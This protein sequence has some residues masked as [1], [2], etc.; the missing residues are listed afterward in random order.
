MSQV[1]VSY[2]H[3]SPDQ[4]LAVKLCRSLEA[5]GFGVF[6]DSK[7]RLGENWV[8]QIDVHL[9]GS[10]HFIALLSA[11]SIKSDM[12]R[13]EIAIAYKL[14]KAKQLTIL[15]VRLDFD[16]E[17]PYELAAYLDFIQY[18]VWHPGESFDPICGTILSVVRDAGSFSLHA[19]LSPDPQRFPSP[20]LETVKLELARH[21]G[22]LAHMIVDRA[23][24]KAANWEQLYDLLASEIPSGEERQKF[25]ATRPR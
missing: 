4:D 14:Q 5:N 24:R 1:F 17:L 10:T 16:E 8:E 23:A 3:V 19:A 2:S 22:P 21:L 12:V 7:I 6:I 13:R 15:P 25:H 9:R 11:A 20:Q 18:I